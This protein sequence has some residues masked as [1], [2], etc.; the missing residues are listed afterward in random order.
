MCVLGGG[1]VWVQA[2][3]VGC[4]GVYAIEARA[5]GVHPAHHGHVAAPIGS[6]FTGRSAFSA[7]VVCFYLRRL[8]CFILYAP[9]EFVSLRPSFH[10]A[11]GA[12]N[13][14]HAELLLL[15]PSCSWLNAFLTLAIR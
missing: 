10:L 1:H 2:G 4:W 11:S 6:D 7:G 8:S 12:K 15:N 3:F 5:W 9:V 13:R 14:P